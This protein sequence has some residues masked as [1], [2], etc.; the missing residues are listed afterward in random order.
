M[1]LLSMTKIIFWWCIFHMLDCNDPRQVLGTTD[2]NDISSA[3][4]IVISNRTGINSVI[5]GIYT[6]NNLIFGNISDDYLTIIPSYY[7]KIHTIEY[8]NKSNSKSTI[9]AFCPTIYFEYC[10]KSLYIY[11]DKG[12]PSQYTKDNNIIVQFEYLSSF[13]VSNND[14]YTNNNNII[15]QINLNSTKSIEGYQYYT[16]TNINTNTSKI[17]ENIYWNCQQSLNGKRTGG[18]GINGD[19]G[20]YNLSQWW[21]IMWQNYGIVIAC[22]LVPCILVFELILLQIFD[23]IGSPCYEFPR[24]ANKQC[25]SFFTQLKI[26]LKS[27]YLSLIVSMFVYQVNLYNKYPLCNKYIQM[28]ININS[29][30]SDMIVV[31]HI[32][33]GVFV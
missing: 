2:I 7:N 4:F 9:L 5:N 29:S 28:N 31:H 16:A 12:F 23:D 10:F 22:T 8:Y 13:N 32:T 11:Q 1:T 6:D 24:V 25:C 15:S 20:N 17:N 30:G 21:L 27:L 18:S 3:D 14:T 33:Y 19:T 26:F